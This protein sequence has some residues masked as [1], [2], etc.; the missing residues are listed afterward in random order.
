MHR[1]DENT[2]IDDSLVTCAE[3]QLFIDEMREQKKFFQ[4]DHWTSWQFPAGQAN[5]PILGVRFSDAQAFC[6]WLSQREEGEW[7]FRLPTAD[8]ATQY[9]IQKHNELFS[10]FWT[11]DGNDHSFAW[12]GPAP[13]NPRGINFSYF[14]NRA[15]DHDIYQTH[16]RDLARDLAHDLARD[17][18]R[19]RNI[20]LTIDHA[21]VCAHE[22][23][24]A[25]NRNLGSTIN[26]AFYLERHDCALDLDFVR[27]I[28][29]VLARSIT[30][31]LSIWIDLI[32]LQERIAGR[33][34]AFE[35]IR[36]VK[37]RRPD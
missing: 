29:F 3:Y 30:F 26:I 16:N 5:T 10:G 28:D 7:H 12:V 18:T 25:Q 23:S 21:R 34:P 1:I 22:L 11:P 37:E 31:I 15:S 19:A 4:P 6:A 36:L 13:V 2:Y 8:E 14:F 9:P 35:G 20:G 32:T 27:S 17:L 24:S 33:S